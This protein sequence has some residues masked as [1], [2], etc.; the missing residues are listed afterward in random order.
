VKQMVEESRA[1]LDAAGYHPGDAVL[2]IHDLPGLLQMHGA[3][4]AGA[5]WYFLA[6]SSANYDCH[7]IQRM[8]ALG[9]QPWLLVNE[10]S[11]LECLRGFPHYS[12]DL[13]FAGSFKDAYQGGNVLIY[14]PNKVR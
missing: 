11:A 4:P 12:N 14:A 3:Y 6:E 8:Q 1:L 9:S 7:H 10:A 5:Y 13:H 2:A